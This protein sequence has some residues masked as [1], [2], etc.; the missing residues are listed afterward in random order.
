MVFDPLYFNLVYMSSNFRGQVLI[1]EELKAVYFSA[2]F[3]RRRVRR[4]RSARRRRRKRRIRR[5]RRRRK[6][7]RRNRNNNNDI[8][9]NR[10]ANND[11]VYNTSAKIYVPFK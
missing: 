10:N 3:I 11:D 7:R 9:I 6:R 4:K 2:Q 5:K 1:F 8:N